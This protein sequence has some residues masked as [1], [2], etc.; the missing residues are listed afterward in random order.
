MSECTHDCSSCSANC[1]SRQNPQDFHEPPHQLSRIK[2][3]IGVV[4]GMISDAQA[5]SVSWISSIGTQI[6]ETAN[7]S[8]QAKIV[9]VKKSRK[10]LAISMLASPVIP[11]RMA[12][13]IPV[14]LAQNRTIMAT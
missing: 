10:A 3:V 8:V 2:K 14:P 6:A 13:K 4:S 11:S 1:A 5:A 9:A 12:P 7:P